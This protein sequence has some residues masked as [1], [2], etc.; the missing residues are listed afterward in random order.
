MIQVFSVLKT[1][2]APFVILSDI[3]LKS[4][5]NSLSSGKNFTFGFYKFLK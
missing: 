5:Q 1:A 2:L 3:N 4:I